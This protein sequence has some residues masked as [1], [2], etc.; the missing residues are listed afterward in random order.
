MRPSAARPSSA[1]SSARSCRLAASPQ[2]RRGAP[3]PCPSLASLILSLEA[4]LNL[5]HS[6]MN[7]TWVRIPSETRVSL[8][9]AQTRRGGRRWPCGGRPGAVQ[10]PPSARPQ[11][12][13]VPR[14]WLPVRTCVSGSVCVWLRAPARGV[15][16][17]ISSRKGINTP[18]Q[19]QCGR[20][21]TQRSSRRLRGGRN[22]ACGAQTARY[23]WFAGPGKRQGG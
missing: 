16:S 7:V 8:A 18:T 6:Y 10:P 15:L 21:T 9:C 12:A 14:P 1:R 23:R 13:P 4:K 22:A 3:H 17:R 20:L 2:A 5:L 19:K 11:R